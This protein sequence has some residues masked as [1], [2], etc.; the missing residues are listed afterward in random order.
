MTKFRNRLSLK[1]QGI[2]LWGKPENNKTITDISMTGTKNTLK[3]DTYYWVK[4]VG[5]ELVSTRI[6]KND[7]VRY[8]FVRPRVKVDLDK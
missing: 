1:Q 5:L 4:L 2:E 6:M 8:K 3:R 7:R